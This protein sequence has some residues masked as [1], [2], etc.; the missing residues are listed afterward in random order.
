MDSPDHWPPPATVRSPHLL[1]YPPPPNLCHNMPSP[2][3]PHFH[4]KFAEGAEQ[5]A[6]A[7]SAQLLHLLGLSL[8][9]FF[10]CPEAFVYIPCGDSNG[11]HSPPE[12]GYGGIHQPWPEGWDGVSLCRQAG[13]QGRNLGSLQPLPPRFKRFSCLSLPSNWDYRSSNAGFPWLPVTLYCPGSNPVLL[14]SKSDPFCLHLIFH[15]IWFS[16]ILCFV[17]FCSQ[18]CFLNSLRNSPRPTHSY[19]LTLLPRLKCSGSI[20]T[21]CSLELL[22]SSDPLAS[23][24]PVAGTQ[25]HHHARLIFAFFCRDE[26]FVILPRLPEV[27][28]TCHKTQSNHSYS[29]NHFLAWIIIIITVAQM[30]SCSVAQSGVQWHNLGSLQPPPPCFKQFSCLSLLSSWDYRYV[31]PHPANFCIFSRDEIS[32]FLTSFFQPLCNYLKAGPRVKPSI[33]GTQHQ[34]GTCHTLVLWGSVPEGVPTYCIVLELEG[35]LEIIIQSHHF[36]EKKTEVP[37]E[38]TFPRSHSK[39]VWA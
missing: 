11:A 37:R 8:N 5:G 34:G 9:F 15:F 28:L 33:H 22:G 26:G 24:S 12:C 23:T 3:L 18:S 14:V 6:L 25:A 36:A 27:P 16:T 30:D 19:S 4:W 7:H 2:T 20:I 38:V 10:Q 39:L 31:P 35:A 29:T 32:P 13:I 17:R 21:H 1:Q